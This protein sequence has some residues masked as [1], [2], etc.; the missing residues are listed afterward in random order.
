MVRKSICLCQCIFYVWQFMCPYFQYLLFNISRTTLY[1]IY[2][3]AVNVIQDTYDKDAV[4][5]KVSLQALALRLKTD[6]FHNNKRADTEM[7]M[8]W[9]VDTKSNVRPTHPK[10]TLQK[11]VFSFTPLSAE[12]LTVNLSHFPLSKMAENRLKL[13]A[14]K[15]QLLSF[16]HTYT[17]QRGGFHI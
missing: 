17:E 9:T 13:K 7:T 6:M 10:N 5:S 4:L 2:Q 12:A 14:L 11:L 3:C 8:L 1:L 15:K 16:L